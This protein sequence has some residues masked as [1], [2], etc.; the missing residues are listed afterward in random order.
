MYPWWSRRICTIPPRAMRS[1]CSPSPTED[2]CT[3]GDLVT[4]ALTSP[5]RTLAQPPQ[6]QKRALMRFRPRVAAIDADMISKPVRR[7]KDLARQDRYMF[8][9]RRLVEFE[10]V[11]FRRHLHPKQKT[12]HRA[13]RP[14]AASCLPW[15]SKSCPLECGQ[16]PTILPTARVGQFVVDPPLASWFA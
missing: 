12:G 14:K 9:Q 8:R 7:R 3:A 13:E 11:G 2:K 6:F 5:P 16:L 4:G 15:P 1:T 10:R